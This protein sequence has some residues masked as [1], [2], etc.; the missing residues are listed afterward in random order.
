[1]AAA[2]AGVERAH[3]QQARHAR[4]ATGRDQALDKFNVRMPEAAPGIAPLIE[5][6]DQIDRDLRVRAAQRTR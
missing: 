6:A 5:D 2:T 4:F 1:M 3:L